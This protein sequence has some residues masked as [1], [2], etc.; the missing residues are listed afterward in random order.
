[1]MNCILEKISSEKV[2][3][4]VHFAYFWGQDKEVGPNPLRG[5]A[6]SARQDKRET[7]FPYRKSQKRMVIK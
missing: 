6:Q 4:S 7:R 5:L 3:K 1:M 2:P